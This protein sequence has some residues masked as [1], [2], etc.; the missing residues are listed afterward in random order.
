V[1]LLTS[2]T[3]RVPAGADRF[4]ALGCELGVHFERVALCDQVLA[5]R[6]RGRG[7]VALDP[8]TRVR[9]CRAVE[10]ITGCAVQGYVFDEP[11]LDGTIRC[12]FTLGGPAGD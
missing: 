5:L 10:E 12:A 8:E 11:G 7:T 4:R 3:E 2:L 1:A 9:M 6:L